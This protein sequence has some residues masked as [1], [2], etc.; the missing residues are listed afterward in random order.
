MLQL[1]I[2][3]VEVF[4]I[5]WICDKPEI[6]FLLHEPVV[7]LCDLNQKLRLPIIVFVIPFLVEDNL[8]DI[9]RFD[10]LVHEPCHADRIILD[11]GRSWIG[12][13]VNLEDNLIPLSDHFIVLVVLEQR[14]Y[15]FFSS[16]VLSW[17]SAISMRWLLLRYL[18]LSLSF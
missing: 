16:L 1:I 8:C 17:L 15:R 13:V 9:A 2:A 18:T 3:R 7:E 11:A 4:S 6:R 14:H 12:V 5:P 10:K